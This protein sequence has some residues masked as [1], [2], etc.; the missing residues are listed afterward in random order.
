MRKMP[1]ERFRQPRLESLDEVV[2]ALTTAA[3]MQN[4]VFNET[5]CRRGAS[6]S[7]AMLSIA[8]HQVV[9]AFRHRPR[10]RS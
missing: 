7:P 2:L 1:E 4:P 6:Y 10:L 3:A 9:D 8:V 5:T